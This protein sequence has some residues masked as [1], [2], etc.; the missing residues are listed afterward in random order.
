[1]PIASP[2]L[3]LSRIAP[4]THSV[5]DPDYVAQ[6]VQARYAV[7]GRVTAELLYRG[8]NDVYIIRDDHGRRAMRIWRAGTRSIDGVMQEL[9]YLDFLD[10]NGI[11]L[12][13][14]VPAKNGDRYISV[15]AIEGM[16]PAVLYSWAPGRKFGD[17]LD[18][19]VAER[20]GGKFAE[21]H[22]IS[23]DYRPKQNVPDDPVAS[24]RDSLPS[25]LLWIEDRPEDIRDY[26]K[27]TETLAERLSRLDDLDLPRGMCHQDMHPSNV[28]LSPDGTITFLDFDGCSL[29]YWLHD[30]RN[31]I[32]GSAFYGFPAVYGEAFERGY[33]KLRPYTADEIA[34][35]ELFL[36]A[37]AFR[38]VSGASRGSSTRGRDLLRLQNLDWFSDYIKPRARALGLL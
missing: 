28:H 3:D 22:L 21:M 37:K 24:L 11:P 31:F 30:V 18:V 17:C 2:T 1:M 38:L 13:K 14:S 25:F 36:L 35:Q 33:L 20:M 29:G 12:S 10:Q 7:A 34:S 4:A 16:R 9:D 23:K 27:L 6:L 26:T 8:V 19:A 15:N 5:I 32:F